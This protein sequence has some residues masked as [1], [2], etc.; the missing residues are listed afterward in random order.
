MR[1][2]GKKHDNAL[3]EAFFHHLPAEQ[4]LVASQWTR[5]E[6]ASVL[7]RL[8][9]MGELSKET[10]GLC[11]ERFSLLLVE[12]FEVVLPEIQG[13][14]FFGVLSCHEFAKEQVGCL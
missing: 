13:G 11:N 10:A 6:F 1:R 9:R 2:Y 8:V 5:V 7:S 14:S 12:N 3:L 4:T